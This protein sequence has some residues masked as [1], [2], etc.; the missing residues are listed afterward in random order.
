MNINEC[1]EQA[2]C[3]HG[4]CLDLDD[5][6]MCTCENGWGG[7]ICAS[8]EEAYVAALSTG[9]ILIMLACLMVVLSKFSYNHHYHISI[10]YT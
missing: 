4:N 8:R 9:T 5:G 10:S 6:F 1:E 7:N 2:P 3:Y